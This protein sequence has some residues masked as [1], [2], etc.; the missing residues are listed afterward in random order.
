LNTFNFI[1]QDEIEKPVDKEDIDATANAK[2]FYK[3]CLDEATLETM[4][5]QALIEFIKTDL[6]DWPLITPS[7]NPNEDTLVEK[8]TRLTKMDIQPLFTFYLEANPKQPN[9]AIL[10]VKKILFKL[11]PLK[12]EF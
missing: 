3:S 1:I 12:T 6:K 4:G 10:R 7:Y 2:R 8:L 9:Q 5:L 11:L